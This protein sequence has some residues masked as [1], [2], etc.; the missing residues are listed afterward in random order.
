[1]S[2]FDDRQKGYESKFA[3]D[4]EMDFKIN[5]RRNKLLGQWAAG[6]LGRHGAEADAYAKD[7][8]MADFEKEGDQDVVDKLLKDFAHAK[9]HVSEKDI[10][11]EMER[12]LAVARKQIME[13]KK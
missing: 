7:V 5:A 2:T 8:V 11:D 6:K 9:L 10:R 4:E 1:M 3:R 13:D 12:L